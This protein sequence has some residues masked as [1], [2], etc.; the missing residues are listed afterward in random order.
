[1]DHKELFGL[2]SEMAG[3]YGMILQNLPMIIPCP[4]TEVQAG[5]GAIADTAVPRT[6]CMDNKR[7]SKKIL[8]GKIRK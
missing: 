3:K 5:E 8:S 1:M 7:Q 4:G 6:E 2:E